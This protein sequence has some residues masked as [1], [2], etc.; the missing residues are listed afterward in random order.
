MRI[1]I[2]QNGWSGQGI[3]GGDK[4]LLEMASFWKSSEE[5]TLLLPKPGKTFLSKYFSDYLQGL[6]ILIASEIPPTSKLTKLPTLLFAYFQRALSSVATLMGLSKFDIAIGSSHFFYDVLP[7]VLCG[8]IKGSKVV[9]YVYHLVSTQS[10]K[11]TLRNH[12][13]I[14][15][16][17]LSLIMIKRFVDLVFTDNPQTKEELTRRGVDQSKIY[18]TKVGIAE[19]KIVN[20]VIKK[21]DLCFVGRLTKNKGVYDVLEALRIVRNFKPKV[22]L[23]FVGTGDEE[24]DLKRAVAGLGLGES[25]DFLGSVSEQ[26]K[27]LVLQKSRIFV[28]PSFEEGWGISL[29]EAMSY[30]LPAVVYEL[31]V[32]KELFKAG[33]VFVELGDVKELAAKIT[34]MLSDES[35]YNTKSEE[36]KYCVRGYFLGP[37]ASEEL[38]F[39]SN[40]EKSIK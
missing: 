24:E 16:E 2:I 5:V 10:R 40:H 1:L 34:I 38:N 6:S 27:I 11:P 22:S 31:P 21:Y 7:A 13:S 15:M 39:I 36:G 12:I 23:V 28:G 9:V 4:H 8:L 14:F 20:D 3:S 29:A 26:E 33:P 30:G 25:V 18:I 35:F 37:A 32:L 19:P 17:N